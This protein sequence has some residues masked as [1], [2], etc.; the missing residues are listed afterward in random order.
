MPEPLTP[1]LSPEYQGEGAQLLSLAWDDDT[2]AAVIPIHGPHDPRTGRELMNSPPPMGRIGTS[3]LPRDSRYP[4]PNRYPQRTRPPGPMMPGTNLPPGAYGGWGGG[5]PGAGPEPLPGRPG[6]SSSVRFPWDNSNSQYGLLGVWSGAEVGVE[7]PVRYWKDVERHWSTCQ[8]PGGEWGYKAKDAKGTLAMTSGGLASLFVTHDWLAAPM[9]KD[10]TG[11][12]PLTRAI[13]KGLAW[14]EEGDNC[15]NTP[16]ALTHYFGYDLYGLERVG[17]ACGYKYFGTHDWYRE[18]AA[19]AVAT[20]SDNGSWGRGRDGPDTLIDTAYTLLFLSRGR[21]PILMNKLQWD[22]S[23][24]TLVDG[25]PAPGYW[26]N[27]PRDVANLT[28]FAS[29][30]LERGLNWQVVSLDVESS[31]WLDAPVLYIASHQAPGLTDAEYEKLRQYVEAGGIIFTHADAAAGP[32]NR[33]VPKLV[34]KVYPGHALQPLPEDHFLYNV[35]YKI[36]APKPQLQAVG[37]GSRLLL[38]HSPTDLAAAWQQRSDKTYGE[39]FRLGVNLFIYAAGKADLRNRLN[40]PFIPE[41]VLDPEGSIQV[42]RLKYGGNWDPEPGAWPRFRRYFEWQTRISV[43]HPPV[44]L[45]DLKF[46]PAGKDGQPIAHLTGTAPYAFTEAEIAAAK[47]FVEAGGTLLI[48]PCGGS[49]AFAESV[50]EALLDRAFAGSKPAPIDPSLLKGNN[51]GD[52][53]VLKPRPFVT[54]AMPNAAAE[55][56]LLKV[57]SGT[58]IVSPLDL[59]SGLLGTNTWGVAGYEPEAAA[60]F[61]RNVLLQAGERK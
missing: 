51:N 27:R 21:H 8:L 26:A 58:V 37:N 17:L 13:G 10:S 35:L 34:E 2:S 30:Q 38:V 55:I 45:K 56:K 61:V 57:G 33:W 19:K 23:D 52:K 41:P 48:D 6:S 60:Q 3:V 42:A 5:L 16:G 14:M 46:D 44:E 28:R 47:L 31:D 24:V 36:K 32:F 9:V 20:Q 25:K 39:V 11:R 18:L 49:P 43:E 7:V 50:R 40:S 12:A 29:R 4:L 22:H 15:V 59:T 54:E 53:L 1:T